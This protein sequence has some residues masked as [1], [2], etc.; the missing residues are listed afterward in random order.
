MTSGHRAI[1]EAVGIPVIASGGVGNCSTWPTALLRDKGRCG[2]GGSIFRRR[3][4]Q[5]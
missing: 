4:Q 5:R 3:L 2:A 1:S